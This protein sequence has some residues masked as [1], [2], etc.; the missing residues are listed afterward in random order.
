MKAKS[1]PRTGRP[2]GPGMAE[3]ALLQRDQANP[4]GVS[5]KENRAMNK[6]RHM[7]RSKLRTE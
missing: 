1:K 2:E 3:F 5:Q 6:R 4:P 7:K